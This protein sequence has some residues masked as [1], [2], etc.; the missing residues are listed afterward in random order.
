MNNSVHH[1][2]VSN[3][4][5]R[6]QADFVIPFLMGFLTEFKGKKY[7]LLFIKAFAGKAEND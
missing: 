1:L 3:D 2:A 5:K 4:Q 6:A 7:R